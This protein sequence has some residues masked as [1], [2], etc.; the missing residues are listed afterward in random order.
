MREPFSRDQF[1]HSRGINLF[2]LQ[3][4]ESIVAGSIAAGSIVA[5]SIVAVPVVAE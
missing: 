2:V 4:L 1:I 3:S 5:R